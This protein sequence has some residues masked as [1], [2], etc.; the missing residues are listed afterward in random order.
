MKWMT[1]LTQRHADSESGEVVHV[2]N[3]SGSG[4]KW[5]LSVHSRIGYVWMGMEMVCARVHFQFLK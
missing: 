1:E 2:L 5:K 3:D 4:E